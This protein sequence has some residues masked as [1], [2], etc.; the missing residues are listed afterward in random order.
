MNISNTYKLIKSSFEKGL[1]ARKFPDRKSVLIAGRDLGYSNETLLIYPSVACRN[2]VTGANALVNGYTILAFVKESEES[3][4][5]YV[6]A[7]PNVA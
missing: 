2:F 6:L 4:T 5:G 7:T 3:D 1:N